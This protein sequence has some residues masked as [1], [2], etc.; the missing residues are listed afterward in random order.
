MEKNI[1]LSDENFKQVYK[2]IVNMAF[3]LIN[4]N[5]SLK[6]FIEE[7]PSIKAD[8]EKI[9]KQLEKN[10]DRKQGDDFDQLFDMSVKHTF[11][12]EFTTD[13]WDGLIDDMQSY[14]DEFGSYKSNNYRN[15]TVTYIAD[16]EIFTIENVGDYTDLVTTQ[17]GLHIIRLDGIQEKGYK[18]FEEVESTIVEELESEYVQLAMKD[19][20]SQFHISDDAVIDNEA[21]DRILEPY[22]S[23]E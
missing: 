15:V 2:K 4:S 14:Y 11:I 12:I 1:V 23:Q 18:T 3:A 16:D 17:F 20:L 7:K 19:Y 10:Q 5:S 21:I 6:L 9:K 8:I 22:A 13:E